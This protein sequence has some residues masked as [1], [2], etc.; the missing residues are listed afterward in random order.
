MSRDP[1]NA[2]TRRAAIIGGGLLAAAGALSSPALA[3][4]PFAKAQAPGY[5][6]RKLGDF[7]V[8]AV[9][10]GDID[11]ELKLFSG[12]A[13]EMQRLS[14][15]SY[16]PSPPRIH[17]NAFAVNTGEKLYLVDTGTGVLLGS[18]L[19]RVAEN[20]VLAGINVDQIDAILLTHLHPD[21]FGGMTMEGRPVFKNA[22]IYVAEA[23]AKFW[24]SAEVADKAPTDFKPFFEMAVAA[25]KPY[26]H[27][28][29]PLPAKGEIASG[30]SAIALPGHTVGHTGYLFASGKEQ[31]LVWG[32]VVHNAA[33]QFERP[34]WTFAADTDREQAAAARKRAFDMVATDKLLVAGM[35]LPYPGLGFVEK[36]G[37]QYRYHADFWSTKL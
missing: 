7:E 9:L 10:D 17:C 22:E 34:E 16:Q 11:L 32:D 27:R 25:I 18:S 37:A 33:L 35:H 3:K 24:L 1:R 30:V 28:L 36:A 12:D 4:M 23:D 2:I 13:A 20:L 19:G 29:K 8:T 6:R 14:A 15:Q 31:M 5:F 21:H 26:A